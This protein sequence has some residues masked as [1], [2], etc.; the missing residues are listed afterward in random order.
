MRLRITFL[1]LL[2]TSVALL[3]Q[4]TRGG[5]RQPITIQGKVIDE[6]TQQPLE[7]ATV[8]VF[9]K[10]DSSI[11]TGGVTNEEGMFI[12]ESRP[13]MFY[14]QV[15]YISYEEKIVDN[16]KAKPETSVVDVGVIAL[17]TNAAT[18]EEI[19]VRAERSQMQ[20]SL[21]K[22]IFNVG[23]DL[24]NAGGNAADILD[25][26]P[27]VTVD[28]EGNVSL[29][30]SGGVRILI[31]GKPSGLVGI[32]NS[33]GLRNLPAEL[34]DRI[35]VITNPS[36]RYEAEGMAGI[37]NIILKKER[38]PGLNGSLTINTGYPDNH[39]IAANVNYRRNKLNF[40]ANYGVRYRR[41]PG[42]SSLYQ[43][44][45]RNDTTF[46]LNQVGDRERGGWSQNFRFGS[47][48][49]ITPK[50]I[51]TAS[52][53]V[54][55]SKDD[56]FSEIIYRDF[57]FNID[58]PTSVTVRTDEEIENEPNQEYVLTYRKNFENKGHELVVDVRYQDNFEEEVSDFTETYFT[59]ELIPN[60]VP[61]LKQRSD[62]AEGEQMLILQADYVYPFS[63]E[64][65]VEFGYRS[66][67]RDIN[68]SFVVENLEDSGWA[69]IDS[70]TNDF[71]YD[72]DVYAIYSQYGNKFG[73][74]SF[75]LG[76]RLEYSDILTELEQTNEVNPR[77]YLN[78]FPSAFFTYDLSGQNAIQIS[79]SRRITRPRFWSLN[80][81]LTFSD[82]RNF[83][84]GNPNLDPE[85]THSFEFGHIKYWEK[86]SLNSSLYY[87]HTDGIIQRIQRVDENGNT[88]TLPENLLTEDAVGLEFTF[89]YSP[90][91][92]ARFNGNINA[93]NSQIDGTNVGAQ[94]EA[95]ATTLFGRMSTILKIPKVM[96][97]QIR[98]NYRAPRNTTQGRTKS[99]AHVDLG[100]SRDIMNDKATLTL[101]V[102]DL[103][104]SRR[105][106]YVTEGRDFFREGDFQWRARQTTLTF[107]YR[108]NQKK[109]RSRDRGD[110]GGGEGGY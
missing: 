80:P 23:K 18:L 92:W 99:I 13:G 77:D 21:D 65:K 98:F 37:I 69:E 63:K 3:A 81:F 88:T 76:L 68:T 4:P 64:G 57:L 35:E 70:L 33:D 67:F 30:G 66:S 75:Q 97:A 11:V 102:R 44:F 46:I 45:Y 91:K 94:F 83:F 24:A 1:L 10:R 42:E 79:Y 71:N 95:N 105:R 72:E 47:D 27:S 103:F 90:V 73:K 53:N 41:G 29:R 5:N 106:R 54:N 12:L 82:A 110:Y 109:Q 39:G 36:A 22:K 55:I 34:I 52:A 60:G 38:Q 62:N 74:V 40:F 9:A 59:P 56:N 78:L 14:I 108:L 20:L 16:I 7:Y 93:F 49:F 15:A 107:N 96:E 61:R 85:F 8:T 31:N 48:I 101:G 2:T 26:V 58:Q 19:E 89:S 51:L 100:F 32:S 104:N 28:V 25:N 86:G 17:K 6:N 43:E 87:R 50:D 84:T